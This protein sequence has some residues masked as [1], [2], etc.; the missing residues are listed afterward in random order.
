MCA[1]SENDKQSYLRGITGFL[2][3]CL[4]L[5]G[6]HLFESSYNKN[7]T[8]DY[9]FSTDSCQEMVSLFTREAQEVNILG[10]KWA[11]MNSW[12]EIRS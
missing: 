8:F 12:I 5:K 11:R 10:L 3:V 9:P 4:N 1:Y 2:F 7:Q 6:G